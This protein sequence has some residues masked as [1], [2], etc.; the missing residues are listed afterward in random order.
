MLVVRLYDVFANLHY[1]VVLL[2]NLY[3]LEGGG[4]K[5]SFEMCFFDVD[6]QRTIQHVHN[7]EDKRN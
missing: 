1:F 2:L 5:L 7:L 4:G 6:V 3:E